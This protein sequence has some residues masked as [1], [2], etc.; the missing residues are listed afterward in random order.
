MNPPFQGKTLAQ[1]SATGVFLFAAISALVSAGGLV[2]LQTSWQVRDGLRLAALV[3]FSLLAV[4][5]ARTAVRAAYLH[6]NDATEYLV[7][8]H[9][10]S[11]IKDV[12]AQIDKISSRTAGGQNLTLAYDN[13][14]PDSGVA[15]PFTWYLRH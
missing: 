4:L 13:S 11:G 12:M 9:G 5:T 2:Y 10:A 14:A 6:P 7:Y 1:L 3:F 8:A 15:W